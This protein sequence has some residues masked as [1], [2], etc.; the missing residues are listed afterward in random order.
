MIDRQIIEAFVPPLHG[1]GGDDPSPL[2]ACVLVP[3]GS[4]KQS[5]VLELTYPVAERTFFLIGGRHCAMMKVE[6][7]RG[8]WGYSHQVELNPLYTNPAPHD[9]RP[10]HNQH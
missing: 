2:P 1:L 10:V 5:G 8:E 6:H 7:D 9:R 3:P 4:I